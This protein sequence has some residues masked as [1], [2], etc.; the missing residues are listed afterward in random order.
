MNRCPCV[1]PGDDLFVFYTQS[2]NYGD[3]SGLRNRAVFVKVTDSLGPL[4]LRLLFSHH[5]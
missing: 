5:K 3:S 1:R 4:K 2:R